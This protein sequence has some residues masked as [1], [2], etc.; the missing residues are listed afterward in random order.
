M[1]AF[2]GSTFS[3]FF[4]IKMKIISSIIFFSIIFATHLSAQ[5]EDKKIHGIS[6]IKPII[7]CDVIDSFIIY[8]A[9][10]IKNKEDGKVTDRQKKFYIDIPKGFN[11]R[12]FGIDY[13]GYYYKFTDS[14]NAFLII[15]A[16]KTI[17]IDS[18]YTCNCKGFSEDIA[19]YYKITLDSAKYC[20]YSSYN[21]YK[22]YYFNIEADKVSLFSKAIKSIRN[23]K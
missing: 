17:K 12:T 15:E 18:I 10:P 19:N 11:Y 9:A 3:T 2:L 16:N 7:P 21:R 13:K 1:N 22:L 23:K 5:N 14:E 8:K 6:K 4:K 20:G